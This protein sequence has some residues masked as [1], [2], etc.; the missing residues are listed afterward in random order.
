MQPSLPARHH[1]VLA[2]QTIESPSL[3]QLLLERSQAAGASFHLIVP[4][5]PPTALQP[6]PIA[7]EGIRTWGGEDVGLALARFRLERVAT[8][9]QRLGLSLTGEVGPADA[10]QAAQQAMARR[11]ADEI[12]VSTL[13]AGAS[14]WLKKGLVQRVQTAYPEV[15]VTHVE[16]KRRPG[17]AAPPDGPRS[18]GSAVPA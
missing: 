2:N 3:R 15:T 16:A 10:F 4:A 18:R 8:N 6:G 14:R 9:L 7:N 17:A 1:L 5:S 12:I 13:P 11:S